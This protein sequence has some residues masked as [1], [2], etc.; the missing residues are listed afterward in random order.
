[1]NIYFMF[2]A[3][4]GEQQGE[5]F[6]DDNS[7]LDGLSVGDQFTIKYRAANPS[8][9]YCDEASSLSRTIRRTIMVV[10]I[11]FAVAVFLIEYFGR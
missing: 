6:V 8:S 10:G 4:G 7:S 3:N 5:F 9:Y 11:M 2:S 1:M